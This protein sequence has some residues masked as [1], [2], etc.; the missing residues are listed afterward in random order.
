[1]GIGIGRLAIGLD[2]GDWKLGLEN[3]NG[4]FGWG[5][6]EGIRVGIQDTDG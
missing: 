6:V 3:D 4:S 2:V 5:L 1:M